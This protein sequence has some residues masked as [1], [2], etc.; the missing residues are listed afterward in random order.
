MLP[1][2][3]IFN[4]CYVSHFLSD[5][6]KV[7]VKMFRIWSS[8][9]WCYR[10]LWEFLVKEKVKF[11]DCLFIPMMLCFVM[12]NSAMRL[13]VL[14]LNMLINL[15]GTCKLLDSL[16]FFFYVI[17][18]SGFEANLTSRNRYIWLFKIMISFGPWAN[19]I[20]EE[21]FWHH[22]ASHASFIYFIFCPYTCCH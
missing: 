6:D 14:N 17:I 15:H 18:W 2:L 19:L 3:Q 10:Y 9:Y 13:T 7:T 20:D 5:L 1:S 12:K 11:I 16:L 4:P 8:S 21:N 22:F